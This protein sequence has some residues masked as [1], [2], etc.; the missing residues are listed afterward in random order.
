MLYVNPAIERIHGRATGEFLEDP[1]LWLKVVHPGDAQM[2]RDWLGA[3][4]PG[5]GATSQ[6]YRILRED[7][8]VRWIEDRARLVLDAGG[9]PVRIDGVATDVTERKN[10]DAQMAYLANHDDLTG[11]PNRNLLNDR[12]ALAL[13]QARRGGRPLAVLFL[14]LDGFK[15]INDSFGHT[16]GDALLKV[17]AER[18]HKAVREGDTVARLGGDEFVVML[19]D[20][21][22]EAAAQVAA[23]LIAALA[24]PLPVDDRKLHVSTSIGVSVFPKDGH[25]G[26]ML[27]KHADVA[28]YRAKE[29]G[30]NGYQFYTEEMSQLTDE[31]V[32]LEAA[33]RHA[34]DN[35]EFE[36][37]YQPQLEIRSG[38]I[39]GMEALIRWRHPRLGLVS[40]ARFIPLAEDNGL[41]V[42]IGEWALRTACAQLKTWHDQGHAGLSVAVNFSARQLHQQDVLQR[43]RQI[44]TET[45]LP[46]QYL[47]MELTETAILQ[48]SSAVI[49]TLR[50]LKAIGVALAMDDFGTGYSSL[51]YLNRFPIDIIKVDQSFT[52]DLIE[53]PDAASIT[54]AIIAMAQS[55]DIRTVAEGVESEAQL[56]FLRNAGCDSIQGHYFSRALSAKE[57]GVLLEESRSALAANDAADQ[58]WTYWRNHA[59]AAR[60]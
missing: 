22:S 30:R 23:H 42:P 40:P 52:L 21:D 43:V 56:R 60:C 28:M 59:A 12:I 11:L 51:S 33:M 3:L 54:R 31:R 38:R 7:G 58:G 17:V 37:H 55:L 2:V 32:E 53:S 26:E 6:Q 4:T 25:S 29:L 13:A 48:N 46:P 14:D 24:R 18:L 49:Q 35:G 5:S 1:T 27:L 10:H 50:E 8:G 44:L 36:L 34:L 20:A 15:F 16:T 9:V 19:P 45:R 41:I 57:M 39:S 47:E